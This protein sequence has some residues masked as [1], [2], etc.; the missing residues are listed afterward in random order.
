MNSKVGLD[1]I[2]RRVIIAI[3]A[4]D[5]LGD[6]LVLKG[7][8]LLQFAYELTTRA[9]K[10]VDVSVD[11]DFEALAA[12]AQRVQTCLK[13]EFAK[14]NFTI[15]DFEFSEVPAQISE[16]LKSFWGGYKCEFKIVSQDAF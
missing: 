5:E 12:L 14:I 11:G 8:N 6:Q 13:S 10:D 15:I 3:L 1:E 16:D 2:K 9:S 4:D 7:G